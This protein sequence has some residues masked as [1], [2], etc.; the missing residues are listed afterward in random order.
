MERIQ[1][2]ERYFTPF[3]DWKIVVVEPGE[4][5]LVETIAEEPERCS[6]RKFG[7]VIKGGKPVYKPQAVPRGPATLGAL[8]GVEAFMPGNNPIRRTIEAANRVRAVGFEPADHGRYAGTGTCGFKEARKADKIPGVHRAYSAK[9]DKFIKTK[10]KAQHFILE[11]AQHHAIGFVL[12]DREF[13]TVLPDDGRYYIN[14]VWFWRRVGIQD[15]RSL[16]VIARCGEI[17]LPVENRT[18]FVVSNS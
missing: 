9:V 3:N 8:D 12:N 13:T 5:D 15:E 7:I 4:V 14:D 10:V 6:D 2:L 17:L 1:T 11:E 18:L 16:P